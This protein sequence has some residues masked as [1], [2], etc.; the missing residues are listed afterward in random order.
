MQDHVTH[1]ILSVTGHRNTEPD[2]SKVLVYVFNTLWQTVLIN[3][4]SFSPNVLLELSYAW[5]FNE[6][7]SFVEEDRRRFVSQETGHLYIAKV[8]PSDVGNYTCVVTS[9]VTTARELGSPTPLVLRPDG[10]TCFQVQSC[11]HVSWYKQKQG[12]GAV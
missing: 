2:C 10:R 8:E 3:G 7:P 1:L 4:L 5:I 6:Y 12:E 9:A 11:V